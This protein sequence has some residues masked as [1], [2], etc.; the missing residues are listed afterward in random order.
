MFDNNIY[1]LIHAQAFAYDLRILTFAYFRAMG[2]TELNTLKMSVFNSAFS[3]QM[4]LL[5]ETNFV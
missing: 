1:N 4:Q 5:V 2:K 3:L